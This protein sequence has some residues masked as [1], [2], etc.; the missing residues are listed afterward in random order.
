MNTLR[1]IICKRA[2][3]GM[4]SGFSVLLLQACCSPGVKPEDA[5][6]FQA[7]CGVSSG[8]YQQ[9]LEASEKEAAK[10]REEVNL[11]AERSRD[12]ENE[13]QTSQNRYQKAQMELNR[14][15]QDNRTLERNIAAMK[16]ASKKDKELKK[17]RFAE[18]NRL[19]GEISQ[20]KSSLEAEPENGQYIEQLNILKQEVETLRLIVLEQ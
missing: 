7:A 16:T 4:I 17:Q 18:L 8:Q 19:N 5:N 3:L 1:P 6:I 15:E 11:E 14:L 2:I 9:D 13:L 12:L 10:S 20:L